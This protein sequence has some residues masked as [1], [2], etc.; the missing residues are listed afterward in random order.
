MTG[1]RRIGLLSWKSSSRVHVL[2]EG[3]VRLLRWV[4]TRARIPN[5]TIA[6][7]VYLQ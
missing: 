4:C 1:L 3:G 2:H 6:H 7:I 5:C